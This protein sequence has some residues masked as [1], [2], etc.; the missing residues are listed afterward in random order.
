MLN[1]YLIGEQVRAISDIRKTEPTRAVTE[2][3][4]RELQLELK[5]KLSA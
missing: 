5:S 3:Y 1:F 4:A 2:L